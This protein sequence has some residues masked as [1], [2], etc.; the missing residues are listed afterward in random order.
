V[1]T[2][3]GK[4]FFFCLGFIGF[5]FSFLEAAGNLVSPNMDFERSLYLVHERLLVLLT[6]ITPP[7]TNRCWEAKR[8]CR[9]VFYILSVFFFL[10]LSMLIF[11]HSSH[12][13][14]SGCLGKA[15]DGAA[16]KWSNGTNTTA[17][18]YFYPSDIFHVSIGYSSTWND[19]RVTLYEMVAATSLNNGASFIPSYNRNISWAP[20]GVEPGPAI[21]LDRSLWNYV[22]SPTEPMVLLEVY[23][24][25]PAPKGVRRIEVRLPVKCGNGHGS[26]SWLFSSG[27]ASYDTVMINE[28][29]WTLPGLS[30]FVISMSTGE[31]WNWGPQSQYIT[32]FLQPWSKEGSL[33]PISPAAALDSRAGFLIN[34][35]F[36]FFLMST[37]NALLLRVILTSGVALVYPASRFFVACCIRFGGAGGALRA[38][39]TNREMD[40]SLNLAYPW[41]GAHV[42]FSRR[43]AA[44][45]AQGPGQGL[46]GGDAGDAGDAVPMIRNPPQ[47]DVQGPPEPHAG[48]G[49]ARE[50]EL[51]AP[52]QPEQNVH[53][54]Q[55]PQPAHLPP[56]PPPPPPPPAPPHGAVAAQQPQDAAALI[57]AGDREVWSFLWAHVQYSFSLFVALQVG[58]V[59]LATLSL[60]GWKST[61]NGLPSSIWAMFF[62]MEVCTLFFSRTERTILLFPRINLALYLAW[63]AY[64]VTTP[65]GFYEEA[66]NCWGIAVGIVFI[67]CMR[68]FEAP[69]LQ[70]GK[71]HITRPRALHS[72]IPAPQPFAPASGMLPPIWTVFLPLNTYFP[73]PRQFFDGEEGGGAYAIPVPPR[74]VDVEE[75][76]PPPP[77]PPH[78]TDEKNF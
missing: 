32:S 9:N 25:Y 19:A 27:L 60:V 29:Q 45:M 37:L 15:L 67:Q 20:N 23:R 69:A 65:Y 43:W 51:N 68:L 73:E 16:F 54:P 53:A 18:A 56:P 59:I 46:M 1:L 4:K 41:L 33:S 24:S 31:V 66:M 26:T 48:G 39:A 14:Q 57:N 30:G 63:C 55:E 21:P 8:F 58:S 64:F 47:P 36:N 7:E 10:T 44:A 2:T 35:L 40:R 75:A 62:I 22:Y 17:G 72:R 61:P 5:F 52:Q 38:E 50:V 6:D 70:A 3:H 42:A 13:G 49:G 28:L 71:I 77:N 78:F 74:P 12:V 11:L 76:P 34:A